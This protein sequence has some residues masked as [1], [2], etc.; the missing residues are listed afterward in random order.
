[1]AGDRQLRPHHV[2]GTPWIRRCRSSS[3]SS[4]P[5]CSSRSTRRVSS[6]LPARR[7][8]RPL[9]RLQ[10]LRAWTVGEGKPPD[11]T[12]MVAPAGLGDAKREQKLS[13]WP[14]GGLS[15]LTSRAVE[16]RTGADKGPSVGGRSP[17][18]TSI[19]HV[20]ASP[21]GHLATPQA[22]RPPLPT[23]LAQRSTVRTE[24]RRELRRT[25]VLRQC[26]PGG[27]PLSDKLGSCP[28]RVA[29]QSAHGSVASSGGPKRT[30]PNNTA[31]PRKRL[32]DMLR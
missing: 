23:G 9:Q 8:L 19:R 32:P 25:P 10:R 26:Q 14:T 16:E 31:E 21:P 13:R 24:I 30:L 3:R 1:M 5:P 17:A 15:E 28:I 6:G 27:L 20:E 29:D 2:T 18:T 11:S 7:A 12:L 4:P 22:T